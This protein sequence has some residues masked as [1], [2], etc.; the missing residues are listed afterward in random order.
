GDQPLGFRHDHRLEVLQLQTIWCRG[1]Y[2]RRATISK[3]QKRQHLFQ[4][5]GRLQVQRTQFNIHYQHFAVLF[6][7]QNMAGQ[8]SCIECSNTSHETNGRALTMGRKAIMI[9]N[10]LVK[11]RRK[12]SGAGGNNQ[13][14]NLSKIELIKCSLRKR[15]SM[16]LVEMHSSGG[17]W[18]SLGAIET[19]G[20]HLVLIAVRFQKRI[21]MLN[22]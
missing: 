13:M 14:R 18:K 1:H 2:T 4:S 11:P 22:L 6:G 17:V 12:K 8:L 10:S 20:I 19:L 16:L 3:N 9:N 5:T 15:R 7:T 21:A